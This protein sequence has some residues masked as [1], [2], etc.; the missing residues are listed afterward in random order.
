MMRLGFAILVIGGGFLQAG[1]M[2]VRSYRVSL[3]DLE[4]ACLESLNWDEE[5]E[6]D[7]FETSGDGGI[8]PFE[9]WRGAL[10]DEAGFKS[11]FLQGSGEV[12]DCRQLI[13]GLMGKETFSGQAVFD[14]K[15]GR[16]VM[17]ADRETH[18]NIASVV[19]SS[20]PLSIMT[21]VSI[22]EV[23]GVRLED[24][25]GIWA[26]VPDGAKLKAALTC[27]GLPGQAF[28]AR[29]GR[30]AL[31]TEVQ[32]DFEDQ[33]VES[34]MTVTVNLP[35][36]AFKW[37]TGF[38]HP[39]GVDW[40]H[41]VGSFDG[42]STLMIVAKQD[43]LSVEGVSADEWVE[44]EKG[45][46][47][48]KEER[49]QRMRWKDPEKDPGFDLSKPFHVFGV[50][51]TFE[52]FMVQGQQGGKLVAKEEFPE[53][54]EEEGDFYG[55]DDLIK[56]NGISFR[57]GDFVVL[58]RR[59]SKLFAKLSKDSL[60]LLKLLIEAGKPEFPKMIRASLVEVEGGDFPSGKI[61]RKIGIWTL[62]GQMAS[63]EFGESLQMEFEA[64]IDGNEEAIEMRVTLSEG[65]K[66]GRKAM[67]K[68]GVT[69]ESGKPVVIQ[70]SEVNGKNKIWVLTA[71][72]VD[73]AVE[74]DEYLKEENK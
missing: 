52:F 18:E 71:E 25:P 3:S 20:M 5:G 42:K 61:L 72:E 44:T 48:L 37:K 63:N 41:E 26:K 60:E 65:E 1:E 32:V 10:V 31:E 62:P 55:L 36:L 16:L 70:E 28:S 58:K 57:E 17:K 68:T 51:P 13:D 23:P 74:V 69:L 30:M 21:E 27:S 39:A 47:F 67:I 33:I 54:K 14:E 59:H 35:G 45:G 6:S 4:R 73:F 8:K 38:V 11:R 22:Y 66:K 29:S 24:R 12:R 56:A 9:S 40:A 64:Q 53:L 49:L 50:P 34:R 15:M 7:P 2:E 19:W 43:L 46:V